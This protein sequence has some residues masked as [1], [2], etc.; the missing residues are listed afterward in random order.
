MKTHL[1][2]AEFVFKKHPGNGIL[3]A[4]YTH[5][6]VEMIYYVKSYAHAL[7]IAGKLERMKLKFEGKI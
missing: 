6:N 7:A 3:T 2:E 4:E 1:D 5:K